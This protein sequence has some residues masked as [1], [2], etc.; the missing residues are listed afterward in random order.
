MISSKYFG[1]EEVPVTDAA[2]DANVEA[3]DAARSS[4]ANLSS[5][6]LVTASILLLLSLSAVA[7]KEV[8]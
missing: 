4:A 5:S 2:G 8:W 3:V 6:Y 1:F 7:T